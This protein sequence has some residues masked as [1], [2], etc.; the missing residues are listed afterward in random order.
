MYGYG[1]SLTANA[2]KR[3]SSFSFFIE[4]KEKKNV[5]KHLQ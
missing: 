4:K 2:L 1:Q 5:S 3:S